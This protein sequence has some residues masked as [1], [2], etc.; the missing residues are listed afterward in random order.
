MP[1]A[2][3]D[4][5]YASDVND[6]ETLLT[7]VEVT[8]GATASAGFTLTSFTGRKVAGVTGVVVFMACTSTITAT[9]GNITDTSMVTLPSGYRP[10]EV[11]PAVWGNGSVDGEA[12]I[13]TAGVV[14][15]RSSTGASI[16]SGTNV[17]LAAAWID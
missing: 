8:T 11:I 16:A 4:I 5:I 1:V 9:S 17:R 10:S 12:T 7:R 6:L 14:T 3:G 2:G 15:L 13:S